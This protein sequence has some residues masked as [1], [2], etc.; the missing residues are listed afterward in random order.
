MPGSFFDDLFTGGPRAV[1]DTTFGQ[2]WNVL[3]Q[4][5]LTANSPGGPDPDRPVIEGLVGIFSDKVEVYKAAH[6]YDPQTEKRPGVITSETRVE[7]PALTPDGPL[8]IR[9]ADIVV[10]VADDSYWRILSVERDLVANR[11]TCGLGQLS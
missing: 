3:P 8:D 10:R 9:A 5:K 7:F 1:L 4:T 6:V 2:A 11:L